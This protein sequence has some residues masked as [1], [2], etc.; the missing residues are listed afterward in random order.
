MQICA[1]IGGEPW[2]VDNMP[3][4][5]QPTMVVGLD[6]YN[7]NG[8]SIIG[9]CSTLNSTF[10]RYSSTVK[11]APLGSDYSQKISEAISESINHVFFFNLVLELQ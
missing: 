5:K 6:V 1:K 9:C 8:Q 2:A 3:F 11:T 10:T 4:T 7:K